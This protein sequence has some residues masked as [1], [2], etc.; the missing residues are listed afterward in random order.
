M[1]WEVD[2]GRTLFCVFACFCA[3]AT[4]AQQAQSNSSKSPCQENDPDD[5]CVLA[6]QIAQTPKIPKQPGTTPKAPP[7]P[8]WPLAGDKAPSGGW[9]AFLKPGGADKDIFSQKYLNKDTGRS[10][11]NEQVLKGGVERSGTRF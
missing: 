9:E 2:M 5:T 6:P 7:K 8:T 3:L 10:I 1:L 11:E 4:N